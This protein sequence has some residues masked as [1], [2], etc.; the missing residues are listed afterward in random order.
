MSTNENLIFSLLVSEPFHPPRLLSITT[1]QLVHIHAHIQKHN[2][3][4][5]GCS[6]PCETTGPKGLSFV[7]D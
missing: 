1:W 2:G 3:S 6:E 7:V 5:N 4:A